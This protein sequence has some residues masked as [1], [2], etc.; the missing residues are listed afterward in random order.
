MHVQ[1][2]PL[3]VRK[4]TMENNDSNH[5]SYYQSVTSKSNTINIF[6]EDIKQKK[7]E[8]LKS[9]EWKNEKHISEKRS[10]KGYHSNLAFF[11]H[12][13]KNL[14]EKENRQ[15]IENDKIGNSYPQ[16]DLKKK[17]N[18]PQQ[19][20]KGN[21]NV[22][23]S[24]ESLLIGAS[25]GGTNTDGKN[26]LG[27]HVRSSNGNS[28]PSKQAH[29]G[30]YGKGDSR[31][32][33]ESNHNSNHLGNHGEGVRLTKELLDDL[34]K[35]NN[36]LGEDSEEE[37]DHDNQNFLIYVKKRIEQKKEEE[38]REKRAERSRRL[39]RKTGGRIR[40]RVSRKITDGQTDGHWGEGYVG[41]PESIPPGHPKS[42]NHIKNPSD[43]TYVNEIIGQYDTEENPN[44]YLE[45]PP[46]ASGYG[47]SPPSGDYN[48]DTKGTS[49][50]NGENYNRLETYKTIEDSSS[51]FSDESTKA[52]VNRKNHVE[53]NM[54]ENPCDIW[55]GLRKRNGKRIFI[56]SLGVNGKNNKNKGR[57]S[58][59]GNAKNGTSRGGHV[60]SAKGRSDLMRSS[61]RS[62]NVVGVVSS[63]TLNLTGIVNGKNTNNKK[64][65]SKNVERYYISK[66]KA[67]NGTLA[68]LS[69]EKPK[70]KKS[71][72]SNIRYV[73]YSA[74]WS[75]SYC[76]NVINSNDGNLSDNT[77]ATMHIDGNCKYNED[78]N[79]YRSGKGNNKHTYNN[80]A[81]Y[82][83]NSKKGHRKNGKSNILLFNKIEGGNN[84]I[85]S[86][87]D[88]HQLA[89]KSSKKKSKKNIMTW[90]GRN[91]N[92]EKKHRVHFAPAKS[93]NKNIYYD[94][95]VT[96]I[97]IKVGGSLGH[98]SD[99]IDKAAAN[100][101]PVTA[102]IS[103]SDAVAS[104]GH[105]LDRNDH[106]DGAN[107][108]EDEEV[109][110][111]S[112]TPIGG[113]NCSMDISA[114]NCE[115][116]DSFPREDNAYVDDPM[117]G[118]SNHLKTHSHSVHS[119]LIKRKENISN[120]TN[121]TPDNKYKTL[122][123]SIPSIACYA[124][125]RQ[126]YNE[127][128]TPSCEKNYIKS[129]CANNGGEYRAEVKPSVDNVCSAS[130][131]KGVGLQGSHQSCKNGTK[132]MNT[133]KK[134][135]INNHSNHTYN[136]V[137]S[138][139]N[140]SVSNKEYEGNYMSYALAPDGGALSTTRIET[141]EYYGRN[142]GKDYVGASNFYHQHGG[143]NGGSNYHT[144]GN[145]HKPF[146]IIKEETFIVTESR[147]KII[148]PD[149]T[150]TGEQ[151]RK[152]KNYYYN[153]AKFDL[154]YEIEDDVRKRKKKKWS[155]NNSGNNG[156]GNCGHGGAPFGNKSFKS[157]RERVQSLL[158]KRR[159]VDF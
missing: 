159:G 62:G 90:S 140:P 68:K 54:C 14:G 109:G 127:N 115:G 156:N 87:N 38:R 136:V 44:E 51:L 65:K 146:D 105:G 61:K 23:K 52:Y 121:V 1:I 85:I 120:D 154:S 40:R 74:E 63:G 116:G 30:A 50:G 64:D 29:Q 110:R 147:E 45:N 137:S 22:D 77:I 86:R 151:N 12:K 19:S 34:N 132:R 114:D 130:Q 67:S 118:D 5:T 69:R 142:K 46:N 122:N 129:S 124:S 4:R 18:N 2:L 41:E 33:H 78:S 98:L 106:S 15:F 148:S 113:K 144:H 99:G 81:T 75:S 112:H 57:N 36:I 58:R 37:G 79:E 73:K 149:I 103:P 143:K 108:K 13:R 101:R 134:H 47:V 60:W 39:G 145:I 43:G 141:G 97:R 126:D 107:N 100:T 55:Y 26:K 83:G 53:F 95:Q 92:Y 6:Y 104:T 125:M 48:D 111:R 119:G 131:H 82:S 102:V 21:A 42:A 31:T 35:R 135:K 3:D 84:F 28:G 152:Y 138:T 91:N 89:K 56:S 157:A 96:K 139:C 158:A 10:K 7:N 9:H 117:K 123:G 128:I 153:N 17:S 27:Q 94:N 59:S 25:A 80:S 76:S 20:G 11:H 88:H 133:H 155:A 24:K 70:R 49:N 71:P 150:Y 32:L 16:R 72:K 8:K 93:G 66:K